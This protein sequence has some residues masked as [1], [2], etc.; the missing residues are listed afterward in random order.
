MSDQTI[1]INMNES[2][3]KYLINRNSKSNVENQSLVQ[4]LE[5]GR[6]N[7]ILVTCPEVNG[8]I[9]RNEYRRRDEQRER[10][11]GN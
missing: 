1:S 7:L 5:I 3:P 10:G 8:H 2:H 9:V 4:I 11:G 6:C